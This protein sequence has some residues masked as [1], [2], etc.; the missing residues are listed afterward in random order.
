[1]ETRKR[2]RDKEKGGDGSDQKM[3]KIEETETELVP[4]A[5]SFRLPTE[6]DQL[7][8]IGMKYSRFSGR[9]NVIPPE[10]FPFQDVFPPIPHPTH[11]DD[12][13]AQFPTRAQTFVKWLKDNDTRLP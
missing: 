7:E 5:E 13:L 1:M 12:W 4:F 3:V 9:S 2:K 8:A 11:I 6:K 10:L